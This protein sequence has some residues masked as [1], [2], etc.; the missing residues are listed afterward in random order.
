[1]LSGFGKEDKKMLNA[2]FKK[3]TK[4]KKL[5]KASKMLQVQLPLNTLFYQKGNFPIV[6]IMK[7]KMFV[8]TERLCVHK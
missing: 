2:K 1:M 8:F 7:V 5:K 3:L 4:T 6:R